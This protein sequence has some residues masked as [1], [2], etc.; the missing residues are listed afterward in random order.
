MSLI[1]LSETVQIELLRRLGAM[2][3]AILAMTGGL[4]FLSWPIM[5][6]CLA[7]ALGVYAAI[8]RPQPPKG[9]VRPDPY[10]SVIVSD[11]IGFGVGISMI[12]LVLLGLFYATGPESL[13]FLL[14]LIPAAFS[15]VIFMISIRQETSWIRFFGNGFE[16]TEYGRPV[17]VKYTDLASV[18]VRFWKVP[19]RLGWLQSLFG[20]DGKKAVALHNGDVDS[21]TLVFTRQDGT[22]FAVSSEVIPDLERIMIGMD[23]AGIDLPD[24]MSDRARRK[25]RR[26]REER[27]GPAT[28]TGMDPA[29]G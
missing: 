8:P 14:F 25:I 7:A 4:T 23:R 21:K 9:A 10:P 15:L 12:T 28:E 6:V 13:L 18:R 2:T 19:G 22:E 16:V 29:A 27:Y 17:R 20:N 5:I 3:I 1:R 26:V 24:G 11:I